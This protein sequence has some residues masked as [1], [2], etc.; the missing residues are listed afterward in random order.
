MVGALL[1]RSTGAQLHLLHVEEEPTERAAA[2]QGSV[3][4]LA[5]RYGAVAAVRALG[6][7]ARP[8]AEIIVEYADDLDDAALCMAA[9]RARPGAPA[10]GSVSAEV[11]RR[12][13]RPV[14][15]VGASG[16]RSPAGLRRVVASVDGTPTG[17]GVVAPAARWARQL[18]VPL[19]LVELVEPDG[20]PFGAASAAPTVAERE[21][22]RLTDLGL[23][24]GWEAL[25]SP[26]PAAAL[27]GYLGGADSLMAMMAAE[28]PATGA[29]APG[30]LAAAVV[31]GAAGPVMLFNPPEPSSPA[32]R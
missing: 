21:A 31:H 18:D 13:A 25:S 5:R 1:A 15:M 7:T 10:L 2:P 27:L 26:D 16:R 28:H 3:R 20:G 29:L 8:P 32:H 4:D 14:L 6:G 12:S 11:L 19:A 22:R 23:S 30:S 17:L 9:G 24:T